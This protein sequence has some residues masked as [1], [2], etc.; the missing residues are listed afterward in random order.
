M[1][2][3]KPNSDA[4]QAIGWGGLIGGVL[5]ISDAL[6]FYGTRGVLPQRLL[7]GIASGL[8]GARALQGGWAAAGLGLALHFLIAFTAAAVYYAV[9]RKLRMLRERPILSGLLYG[10]AVFLFMNMVVLPLS[11]IHQSPT[12]WMQVSIASANAVLAVMLFVG[13]PIAI[14][15]NRFAR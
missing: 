3:E 11:A 5:D 6:L 14:S 15:V 1:P 10:F 13:L 7:Q 9:S 12:A 2:P 4:L 8:L